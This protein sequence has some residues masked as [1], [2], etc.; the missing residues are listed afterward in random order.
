MGFYFTSIRK[1][2]EDSN[3]KIPSDI[4]SFKRF[5]RERAGVVINTCVGVKGE[6]FEQ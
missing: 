2:I 4:Q 1:R 3:F 5:Y 6:E